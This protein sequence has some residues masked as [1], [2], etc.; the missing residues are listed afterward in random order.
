MCSLDTQ[1]WK[2]AYQLIDD[3]FIGEKM[4]IGCDFLEKSEELDKKDIV[5]VCKGVYDIVVCSKKRNLTK[6]D[7]L[8]TWSKYFWPNEKLVYY[9]A[10]KYGNFPIAANSITVLGPQAWVYTLM[11]IAMVTVFYLPFIVCKGL[12]TIHNTQNVTR[13]GTGFIVLAISLFY[14]YQSNANYTEQFYVNK[15]AENFFSALYVRVYQNPDM[16]AI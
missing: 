12:P 16:R 8:K 9:L 3:I 11:V 13:T 1:D 15:Q 4:Y 5:V 2:M 7:F 14:C 10:E 6:E